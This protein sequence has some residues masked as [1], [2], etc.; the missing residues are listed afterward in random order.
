VLALADVDALQ[1][2]RNEAPATGAEGLM[3]KRRD[4]AY[5]E[6]RRGGIW[7]KW[8]VAPRIARW[9]RDKTPADI[10]TLDTLQAMA[11]GTA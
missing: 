1:D 11:D 8:K 10:D 6:G 5:P 2:A 9:R 3:L 7:L 4:A